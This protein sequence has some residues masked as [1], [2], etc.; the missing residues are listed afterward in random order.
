MQIFAVKLT[1]SGL[2]MTKNA[3]ATNNAP[4]THLGELT[5]LPRLPSWWVKGSLL[6]SK[7]PTFAFG[8]W[9]QS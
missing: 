8:L 3:L 7:N 9:R 1:F 6:P 5:T 2:F 4:W